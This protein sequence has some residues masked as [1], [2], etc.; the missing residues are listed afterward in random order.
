[1][2]VVLQSEGPESGDLLEAFVQIRDIA[3]CNDTYSGVVTDNMICAGPPSGF[4]GPCFV[5]GLKY[6]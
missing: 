6:Y 5:R 1:M 3:S 4:V 2:F